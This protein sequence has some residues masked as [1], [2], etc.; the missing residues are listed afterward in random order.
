[1]RYGGQ[2][3]KK[4]SESLY[5]FFNF[6]NKIKG[7]TCKDKQKGK[8]IINLPK[9]KVHGQKKSFYLILNT[10]WKLKLER[11]TNHKN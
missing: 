8:M 3:Q 9:K 11:L 6:Q 5:E 1:M 7:W 2:A 4:V 10:E